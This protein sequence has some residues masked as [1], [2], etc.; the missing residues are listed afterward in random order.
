ML[1]QCI[2]FQLCAFLKYIY[3]Y[4][5]MCISIHSYRTIATVLNKKALGNKIKI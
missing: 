2:S 5:Y 4:V 1:E 3:V